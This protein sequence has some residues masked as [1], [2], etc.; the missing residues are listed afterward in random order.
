MARLTLP[1]VA[2]LYIGSHFEVGLC[3]R[4]PNIETTVLVLLGSGRYC[5]VAN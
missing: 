4:L 5:E 1:R 2:L 3:L